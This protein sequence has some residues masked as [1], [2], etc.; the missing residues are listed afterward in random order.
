M[1]SDLGVMRQSL[2]FQGI[3]AIARN[4]NHKVGDIRLFEFGRTYAKKG[5]GYAEIEHLSLFV[6]G[7]QSVEN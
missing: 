7:N 6:S 4:R 5:E 3:E 2:V 1:S